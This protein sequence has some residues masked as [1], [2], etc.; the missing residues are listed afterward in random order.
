MREAAGEGVRAGGRAR[1]E[2]AR[3]A[4]EVA[5]TA[6]TTEAPRVGWAAAPLAL[7]M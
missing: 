4:C 2:V 6:T 3:P 1:A 7:R 5:A